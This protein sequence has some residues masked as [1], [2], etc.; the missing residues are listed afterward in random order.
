MTKNKVAAPV[1]EHRN[2]REARE[3]ITKTRIFIVPKIRA[4]VHN[5]VVGLGAAGVGLFIGAGIPQLLGIVSFRPWPL[6]LGVLMT[7]VGCWEEVRGDAAERNS[8]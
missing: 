1:L 4:F 5:F 6:V 7:V 3:T 8:H 2:G